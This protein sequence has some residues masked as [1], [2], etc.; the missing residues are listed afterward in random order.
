MHPNQQ[1]L[2]IVLHP[3]YPALA[4]KYLMSKKESGQKSYC[5]IQTLL[6]QFLLDINFQI[7]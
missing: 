2:I 7:S 1:S 5:G 3:F 6:E 4:L